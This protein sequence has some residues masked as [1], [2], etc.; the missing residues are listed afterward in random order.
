MLE[1]RFREEVIYWLSQYNTAKQRLDELS[2]QLKQS[3]GEIISLRE[4]VSNLE[5]QYNA[6][7]EEINKLDELEK[8]STSAIAYYR[9]KM[10]ETIS[11]LR[12]TIER[13]RVILGDDRTAF[14][15]STV[16]IL[17]DLK[18]TQKIAESFVLFSFDIKF[19]LETNKGN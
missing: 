10:D 9:E 13:Y 12:K 19:C 5:N 2:N 16:K 8:E 14:E 1:S 11:N 15:S 7:K 18:I 3:E 4:K 17:E 6:A